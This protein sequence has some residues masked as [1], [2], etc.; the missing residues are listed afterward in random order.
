MIR[1][2]A[3]STCDLPQEMFSLYNIETVP[4]KVSIG[5]QTYDDKIDITTSDLFK[6]IE[7][8]DELSVT[9]AP[10]PEQYRVLMEKATR[11]GDSVI[12]VCISSGLSA[13]VQSAT[14]GA[15][16]AGGKI[17]I[18]DSRT[19]SLG[20]GLVTLMAARMAAEGAS[21]DDIVRA[22]R[23][24]VARQRTI[25]ILD[26]VEYLRKGGRIG[27]VAARMV[28]ILGIK[29][30]INVEKDGTNAVLHKVRGYQ[31]GM[32][33]M[34]H[35]VLDTA[36]DLTKQTIGIAYS[37]LEGSARQFREMLERHVKP[38]EV[39]MCGL[40]SV[41]A[42]HIGPNAFGVFWEEK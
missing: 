39:L 9:S 5:G 25:L 16:M 31:K 12:C 22:C 7:K 42:T 2:I 23:E 19:T 27:S 36:R 4:L 20:C 34:L 6:L 21:H 15:Q 10:A 38:K 11:E 13:S 26:T 29:P 28:G 40:G 32:E 41:V 17:D 35:Y 14:L 3:D 33:W 1:I 24:K 30:I 18:V 8:Y 37:S